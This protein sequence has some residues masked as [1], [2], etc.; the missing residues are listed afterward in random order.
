MPPEKLKMVKDLGQKEIFLSLA[1]VKDGGRLFLG[2]SDGKVYDV[3][4]LAEK[5]EMKSWEGHS[6]YV[7]GLALSNETLVSGS[8]DGKLIWRSIVTGEIIR[9]LTINPERRYHGTGRPP[10][11]PRRPRKSK[12][13]NP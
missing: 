1:R 9:T 13:P 2:A 11:G 5:P 12:D 6:T 3:D 4:L 10:G 8:Y 7:T